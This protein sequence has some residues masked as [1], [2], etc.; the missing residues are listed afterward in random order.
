VTTAGYLCVY[1]STS[2]VVNMAAETESTFLS[3]P[4]IPLDAGNILVTGAQKFGTTLALS[5]PAPG[6]A[7][8]FGSWALS[9]P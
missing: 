5:V 2:S 3:Q 7:R 9:A 6:A 8:A 1:V 4:F